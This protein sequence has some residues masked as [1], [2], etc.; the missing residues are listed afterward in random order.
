MRSVQTV[1][2]QVSRLKKVNDG[3]MTIDDSETA[4]ELCNYFG[5]VFVKDNSKSDPSAEEPK[6]QDHNGSQ[7]ET[8]I[9]FDYDLVRKKLLHLQEDKSP[10]PDGI[11]PLVLK[12]C[13]E[14]L[15]TPLSIIFQK[16]YTDGKIPNDWK[17]ANISPIHKKGSKD[18]PENYRPISL[19]SVVSKVMESIIKEKVTGVLDNR[20]CINCN[21][22]GFWSF[23]PYESA[24][25]PR[26]LDK[27]SG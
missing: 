27:T 20:D 7:T 17:L 5:S 24:R 12:R 15:A 13:T 14:V 22:H 3:T 21:Q 10:G 19:T 1:K 18:E 26:S 8:E 9:H 23:L 25:D 11:H 6:T 16:S 2:C 4:Q